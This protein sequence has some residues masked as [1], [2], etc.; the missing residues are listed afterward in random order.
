M[1]DPLKIHQVQVAYKTYIVNVRQKLFRRILS[2]SEFKL[3]SLGEKISSE[4]QR[5]FS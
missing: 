4:N 3:N 2:M 1:K 5:A